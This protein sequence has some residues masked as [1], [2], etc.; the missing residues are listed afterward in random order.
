MTLLKNIEAQGYTGYETKRV[1]KIEKQI[2]A[3]LLKENLVIIIEGTYLYTT[4]TYQKMVGLILKGKAIGEE[5]TIQEAREHL[6]LSRKYMLPLLNQMEREGY[7][8]RIGD[9][10]RV[11]KLISP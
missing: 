10:R 11:M 2:V 9:I 4:A 1:S 8:R 7:L 5:F 6:S 3:T